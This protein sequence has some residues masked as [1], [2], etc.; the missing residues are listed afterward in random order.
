M[1]VVIFTY[2][3][4]WVRDSNKIADVF[5]TDINRALRDGAWR[6]VPDS[7]KFQFSIGL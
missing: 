1:Q 5:V 3:D 2:H 7:F 4:K 6:P